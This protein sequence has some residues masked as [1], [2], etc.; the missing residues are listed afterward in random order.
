VYNVEFDEAFRGGRRYNDKAARMVRRYSQLLD[1]LDAENTTLQDVPQDRREEIELKVHR[2]ILG[3]SK[4]A[5]NA[6]AAKFEELIQ[7]ERQEPAPSNAQQEM[8]KQEFIENFSARQKKWDD[9]R[10]EED[11]PTW[12]Q[13]KARESIKAGRELSDDEAIEAIGQQEQFTR[14]MSKK[15]K[16]YKTLQAPLKL[17]GQGYYFAL[18]ALQE[19]FPYYIKRVE[20]YPPN[21]TEGSSV[22]GT[23]R[24]YVQRNYNRPKAAKEGYWANDI[25]GFQGETGSIR[26]KEAQTGKIQA[27]YTNY[28]NYANRQRVNAGIKTG[29]SG[30]TKPDLKLTPVSGKSPLGIPL[31]IDAP[32]SESPHMEQMRQAGIVEL[33]RQIAGVSV[34]F[35]D[36]LD[37][38]AQK[39]MKQIGVGGV[40][41]KRIGNWT[42]TENLLNDEKTRDQTIKDLEDE[43]DSIFSGSG[44]TDPNSQAIRNAVKGN[45]LADY[46]K[47]VVA[48]RIKKIGTAG[49]AVSDKSSYF[50]L[51][52]QFMPGRSDEEYK[53]V[54]GSDPDIERVVKT[55]P[56]NEETFPD[57]FRKAESELLRMDATTDPNMAITY[58][59]KTYQR[60]DA[61]LLR[62]TMQKDAIGFIKHRQLRRLMKGATKIEPE[63]ES[64]TVSPLFNRDPEPPDP[65]PTPEGGNVIGFSRAKG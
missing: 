34:P 48:N 55:R 56:I 60:L 52:D 32:T 2:E 23:D 35:K 58:L 22:M 16:E 30:E 6:R 24:G 4:E 11:A 3:D 40:G 57:E 25:E 64:A 62:A 43:L 28:Q 65:E 51:G 53:L 45:M 44:G 33:A 27:N 1:T 63:Q 15:R 13:M 17:N 21:D 47:L 59:D 46:N 37:Q 9:N 38:N 61:N 31:S 26:G 39:E 7:A 10:Q 41:Y 8:W 12:E 5:A 49:A 50:A 36:P 54:L 14:F 18:Q 19:Q 29:G 20:W 42:E